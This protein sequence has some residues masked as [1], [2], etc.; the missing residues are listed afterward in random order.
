MSSGGAGRCPGLNR[1][2]VSE[3]LLVDYLFD[4]VAGREPHSDVGPMD[5]QRPFVDLDRAGTRNRFA[6]L[7][8]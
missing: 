5:G 1:D 8:E 6:A 2:E 4:G 3:R 7:L